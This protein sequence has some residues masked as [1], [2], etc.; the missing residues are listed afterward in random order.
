M[1]KFD[2]FMI[3]VTGMATPPPVIG[4]EKIQIEFGHYESF[5]VADA[6]KEF[7][8]ASTCGFILRLPVL[9][10]YETFM[11]RMLTSIGVTQFFKQ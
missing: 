9:D 3:F 1:D 4:F 2:D 7:A 6:T 11:K 10:E 8:V 5:A